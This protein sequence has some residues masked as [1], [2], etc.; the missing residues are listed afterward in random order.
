MDAIIPHAAWRQQNIATKY[1]D[2][3]ATSPLMQRIFRKQVPQR[4]LAY[5][6]GALEKLLVTVAPPR[7]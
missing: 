4:Q 2:A 5:Q 1:R 3:T 7:G 6:F